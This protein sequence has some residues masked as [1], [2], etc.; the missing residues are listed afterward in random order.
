MSDDVMMRHGLFA[1]LPFRTFI[2]VAA[3]GCLWCSHLWSRRPREGWFLLRMI[4]H[5]T[6]TVVYR[7]PHRYIYIYIHS[8]P[9]HLSRAITCHH[10]TIYIYNTHTYIYI[11]HIL[12]RH[13]PHMPSTNTVSSR[14]LGL[15]IQ[16]AQ[17]PLHFDCL[18]LRS[19]VSDAIERCR[20]LAATLVLWRV[21]RV[22]HFSYFA[23]TT[24][25]NSLQ[26]KGV[27]GKFMSCCYANLMNMFFQWSRECTIETPN[28]WS[29]IISDHLYQWD[30]RC[31]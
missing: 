7:I 19:S 22:P 29:H 12:Y 17:H 2:Q 8:C 10:H 26:S 11:L 9:M 4:T 25:L 13:E 31:N 5:D 3:K 30:H 18:L 6:V 24:A 27:S 1:S 16:C 21:W 28:K 20:H 23:R 14:L 15:Q